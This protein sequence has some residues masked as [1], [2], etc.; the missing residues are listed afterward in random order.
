MQDQGQTMRS[1][2]Q[3]P[4]VRDRIGEEDRIAVVGSAIAPLQ[5]HTNVDAASKQTDDRSANVL[6]YIHTY[7]Y[8][9]GIA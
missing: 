4:P 6:T 7:I 1:I 3:F 5:T 2:S 8:L 9:H